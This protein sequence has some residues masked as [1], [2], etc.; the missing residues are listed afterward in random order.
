MYKRKAGITSRYL[1][2]EIK[3]LIKDR[4]SNQAQIAMKLGITRKHLNSL[5][6]CRSKIY[7][8]DAFELARLLEIED[9]YVLKLLRR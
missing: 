8:E 1:M 5:L 9:D 3:D 6:N 7:L 4:K 2:E